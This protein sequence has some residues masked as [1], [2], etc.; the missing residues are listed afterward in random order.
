V[1]PQLALE[2][3]KLACKN[4]RNEQFLQNKLAAKHCLPSRALSLAVKRSRSLAVAPSTLW[5]CVRATMSPI[6]GKV[7]VLHLLNAL[8]VRKNTIT[9]MSGTTNCA[10][11]FL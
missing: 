9:L 6:C 1:V 11:H 3:R 2:G 7:R 10:L 8:H 5:W 4:A